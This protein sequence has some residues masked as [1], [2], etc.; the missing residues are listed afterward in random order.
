MPLV[1]NL[2]HIVQECLLAFVTPFGAWWLNKYLLKNIFLREREWWKWIIGDI[3][4]RSLKSYTK[5]HFLEEHAFQIAK[6]P[7]TLLVYPGLFHKLPTFS[8]SFVCWIFYH[9]PP[10][11]EK[12]EYPHHQQFIFKIYKYTFWYPVPCV[13]LM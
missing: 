2:Q 12:K 3:C 10:P 1:N 13:M 5:L 8:N 9:P 11:R 6:P 7:T 4:H